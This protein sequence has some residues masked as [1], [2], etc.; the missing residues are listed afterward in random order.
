MIERFSIV[1]LTL[2][3][4]QKLA[5]AAQARGQRLAPSFPPEV[6]DVAAD[7]G[8]IERV[9]TNLLDNAIRHT[10]VGGAIR[11]GLAL[12]GER[13]RV[14]IEDSGPGFAPELRAQLFAPNGNI[15][16]P[17]HGGGLGLLI[18]RQIMR[19]HGDDLVLDDRPGAGTVSAF[20]LRREG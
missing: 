5:L 17:T 6:A 18:V 19:L 14:E 7:I 16:H 1:E 15:T 2:D 20:S 4:V 8:M 9:L 3:V 13:V 11:I 12:R 10:P